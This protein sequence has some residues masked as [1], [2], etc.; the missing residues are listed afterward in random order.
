MVF[1]NSAGSSTVRGR[2]RC[3]PSLQRGMSYYLEGFWALLRRGDLH[4]KCRNAYLSSY[5]VKKTMTGGSGVLIAV[6]LPRLPTMTEVALLPE[7]SVV[8]VERAVERRLRLALP[9]TDALLP[10]NDRGLVTEALLCIGLR[11][12]V[13]GASVGTGRLCGCHI[14]NMPLPVLCGF[15]EPLMAQETFFL[16]DHQTAEGARTNRRT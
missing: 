10:L 6:P 1:G 15:A 8:E 4:L 2:R 11:G 14:C 12:S 13:P 7:K 16:S 3:D 9:A 5:M